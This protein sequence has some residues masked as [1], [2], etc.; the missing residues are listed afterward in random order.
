MGP[1]SRK[2]IDIGMILRLGDGDTN[3]AGEEKDVQIMALLEGFGDIWAYGA[4]ILQCP[5]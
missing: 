5:P 4:T 2:P 1:E 3:M